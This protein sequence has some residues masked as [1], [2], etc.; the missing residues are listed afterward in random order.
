ML[1]YK[2]NI[3]LS[4]CF[5]ALWRSHISSSICRAL[6]CLLYASFN[7]R[8][9]TLYQFFGAKIGFSVLCARY[10]YGYMFHENILFRIICHSGN[11]SEKKPWRKTM[12]TVSSSLKYILREKRRNSKVFEPFLCKLTVPL[13]IFIGGYWKSLLSW[14]NHCFNNHSWRTFLKSGKLCTPLQM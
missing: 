7:S 9:L 11:K 6:W 2:F 3:F 14:N 12:G 4:Y 5:A 8:E 1:R 10:F 13:E